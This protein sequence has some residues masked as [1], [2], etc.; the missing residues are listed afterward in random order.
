MVRLRWGKAPL[1]SSGISERVATVATQDGRTA[2][3]KVRAEMSGLLRTTQHA[4]D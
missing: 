1:G 2:L 4:L 3:Q